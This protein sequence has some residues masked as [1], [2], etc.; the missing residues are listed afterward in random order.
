M[1]VGKFVPILNF[2]ADVKTHIEKLLTGKTC[3][4]ERE[5]FCKDGIFKLYAK[6]KMV[7]EQNSAYIIQ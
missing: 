5:K 3:E 2:L 4:R 6:W 7:V 1:L